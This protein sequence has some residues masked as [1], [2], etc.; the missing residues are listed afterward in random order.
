AHLLSH[1]LRLGRV[2]VL[3]QPLQQR[4]QHRSALPPRVRVRALHVP[5]Q[6]GRVARHVV[7]A[8]GARVRACGRV[9]RLR[10]RYGARRGAAAPVAGEAIVGA[11]HR[12]SPSAR[13]RSPC[14]VRIQRTSPFRGERIHSWTNS[15]RVNMRRAAL[16]VLWPSLIAISRPSDQRSQHPAIGASSRKARRN[17]NCAL[18]GLRLIAQSLL[19]GSTISPV[20][21]S[22]CPRRRCVSLAAARSRTSRTASLTSLSTAAGTPF[23]SPAS[24][25]HTSSSSLRSNTVSETSPV[26]NTSASNT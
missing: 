18:V 24:S 10:L 23:L 16:G 4:V 12:F 13:T 22:V 9:L 15:I 17:R 2:A 6:P 7:L 26:V 8:E 5:R 11:D 20:S 3:V 21:G 25:M 1:P 14:G 19:T